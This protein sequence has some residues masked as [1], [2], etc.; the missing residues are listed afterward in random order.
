VAVLV[1]RGCTNRQI[2][3]RLLIAERTAMRHVEHL[4][5]KL[6]VH[7]RAEVGAWVARHGLDRPDGSA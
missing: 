5:T 1:A 2:A 4:F 7:S 6:G 3:N